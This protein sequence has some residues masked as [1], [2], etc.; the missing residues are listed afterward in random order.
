MINNLQFNLTDD[1]DETQLIRRLSDAYVIRKS[2]TTTARFAIYDTFDWRLFKKSLTLYSF[3][4]RFYL[5]KLSKN[6]FLES[7]EIKPIP[8]FIWDFADGP[9][10]DRLAPV[11]KMRAL[12]KLVEFSSRSTPYRVLD[13]VEKTVARLVFED[14]YPPRKRSGSIIYG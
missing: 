6:D 13:T 14:F 5:R 1:H 7:A 2:R 12:L 8:G 11:I 10:K 3:G 4:D 9:L